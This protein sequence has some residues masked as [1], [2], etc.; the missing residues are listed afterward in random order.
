MPPHVGQ[1][2]AEEVFWIAIDPGTYRSLTLGR[3]LSP[4]DF[5]NWINNSFK[6]APPLTKPPKHSHDRAISTSSSWQA[7]DFA[8]ALTSHPPRRSLTSAT[9]QRAEGTITAPPDT[10]E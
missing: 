5:E 4:D 10:P 1:R 2:Y 8:E 3:G 7:N 9:R 6:D